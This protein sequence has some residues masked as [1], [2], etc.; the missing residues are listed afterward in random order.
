M[1]I[2]SFVFSGIQTQE[3]AYRA[4][5][6]HTHTSIGIS[7]IVHTNQTMPPLLKKPHA[8]NLGLFSPDGFSL[9]QHESHKWDSSQIF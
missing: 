3:S 2:A 9:A 8:H 1:H 7:F 6:A 4:R 5:S